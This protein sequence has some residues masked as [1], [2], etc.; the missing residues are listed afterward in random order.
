MSVLTAPTLVL[1]KSW[2]PI[3]SITVRD[4]L[5]DVIA[6]RGLFLHKEDY[7]KHDMR[8]WMDLPVNDAE[9]SIKTASG[10][11][12]VP[13]IMLLTE[14]SQVPFRK[15]VFSRRNIWKRDQKHCQYCGVE[16]PPDAVSI[17]HIIPRSKGGETSFENCVLCCMKCNL[18]KGNKSLQQA[19]MKLQ[20]LK[21]LPDGTVTV[22]SYDKPKRPVWN[23]LYAVKRRTFPKSWA[24]FLKNFN[25]DL[26][27]DVELED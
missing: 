9:P 12:L 13:E 5:C 26:Y 25:E 8:S 1:N 27:W 23:P 17:D 3:D 10:S 18:K 16:P 15:V 20:K 21:K 2:Y 19:G 4:A 24:A 11:I 22:V 14:Y 6:E 7:T